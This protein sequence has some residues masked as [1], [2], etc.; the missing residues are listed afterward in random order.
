MLQNQHYADEDMMTIID[1]SLKSSEDTSLDSSAQRRA[2]LH[3]ALNYTCPPER[4]PNPQN[5]HSV[6][7]KILSFKGSS[8][9]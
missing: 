7:L 5:L 2:F 8:D 9:I 1:S 4:S 3:V 6:A